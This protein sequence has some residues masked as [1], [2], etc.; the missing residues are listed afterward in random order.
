[1]IR[2]DGDDGDEIAAVENRISAVGAHS[3]LGAAEE[4]AA[5][6]NGLQTDGSAR[7]A[8]F[9]SRLKS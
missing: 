9:T 3:D 5:R 4:D 2:I 1:V 6:L 7:Y 8:V